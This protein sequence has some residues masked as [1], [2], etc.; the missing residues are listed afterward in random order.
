MLILH[1][2]NSEDPELCDKN[3]NNTLLEIVGSDL[4]FIY[5]YVEHIIEIRF[6]L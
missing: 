3:T 6:R 2:K 4:K 5:E 1:K